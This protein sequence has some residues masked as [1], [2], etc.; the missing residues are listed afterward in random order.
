[1]YFTIYNI[2]HSTFTENICIIL[3]S[4]YTLY[5]TC[6][7]YC[8]V[9]I[10]YTAKYIYTIIHYTVL[11]TVQYC[12]PFIWNILNLPWVCWLLP[13]WRRCPGGPAWPGWAPPSSPGPAGSRPP[14]SP[15]RRHSGSV[16][17]AH[18]QR[19]SS[20]GFSLLCIVWLAPPCRGRVRVR[21]A[22]PPPPPAPLQGK[23]CVSWKAGVAG[24][25]GGEATVSLFKKQSGGAAGQ[26]IHFRHYWSPRVTSLVT[27]VTMYCK[28][29]LSSYFLRSYFQKASWILDWFG[30]IIMK[31]PAR[32]VW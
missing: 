1:M 28:P 20:H 15:P 8:A 5:S 9:D 3:Y 2:M 17:P 14:P 23:W 16:L 18:R 27:L 30:S 6:I 11:Y 31:T 10:N 25:G 21:S 4:T 24:R 13:V 29:K 12:I 32:V 7:L 26:P 22:P 19:Q